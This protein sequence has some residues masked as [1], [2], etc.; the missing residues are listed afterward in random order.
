MQATKR[1]DEK[2]Y[3]SAKACG[4]WTLVWS[5]AAITWGALWG[6]GFIAFLAGVAS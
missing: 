2:D 3:I 4:I 6:L 1:N 5:T